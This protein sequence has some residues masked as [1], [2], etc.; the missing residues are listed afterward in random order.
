MLAWSG[1]V[2]YDAVAVSL[3]YIAL[4]FALV[5]VML[6][7]QCYFGRNR[8]DMGYFGFVFPL[9]AFCLACMSSYLYRTLNLT[10]NIGSLNLDYYHFLAM[11]SLCLASYVCAVQVAHVIAGKAP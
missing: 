6:V 9:E 2:N 5:M 8:F 4:M 7:L 10:N 3:F 11:G 1:L